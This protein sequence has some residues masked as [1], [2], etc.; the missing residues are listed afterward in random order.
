MFVIDDLIDLLLKHDFV[1]DEHKHMEKMV[2][3]ANK[4]HMIIL[5]IDLF[6][7]VFNR[8][9]FCGPMHFVT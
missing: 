6:L 8:V 5:S 7:F 1:S 3:I 4:K 9:E 2:L